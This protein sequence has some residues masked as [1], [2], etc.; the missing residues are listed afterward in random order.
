L[1]APNPIYFGTGVFE[2]SVRPCA[3]SGEIWQKDYLQMWEDNYLFYIDRLDLLENVVYAH[4]SFQTAF[5]K[6]G[7]YSVYMDGCCRPVIQ[8]NK[9]TL[10]FHLRAGIQ[11]YAA[12]Q[13]GGEA[14]PYAKQSIVVNMP[15]TVVLRQG[16]VS[17]DDCRNLPCNERMGDDVVCYLFFQVQTYHPIKEY[18]SK[19]RAFP[20][21]VTVQIQ[22]LF[23]FCLCLSN[24]L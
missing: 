17:Y 20:L 2:C 1:P 16:G 14:R 21:F 24:A 13:P 10:P 15:E 19:I 18:R 7:D 9:F 22:S 4:F 12:G 11:I 6:N 8:K 23:A 5:D 3:E